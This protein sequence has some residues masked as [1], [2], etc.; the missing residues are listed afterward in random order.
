MTAAGCSRTSAGHCAMA[1]S[2]AGRSPT[3]SRTSTGWGWT[4][5]NPQRVPLRRAALS[6]AALSRVIQ[7]RV[8]LFELFLARVAALVEVGA[9]GQR[10]AARLRLGLATAAHRP[11]QVE[12]R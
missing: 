9:G 1:V 7:P 3:P 6:A 5:L 12:P 10:Q 2:R 4:S 11:R 8:D